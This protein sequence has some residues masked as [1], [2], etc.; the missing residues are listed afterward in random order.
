MEGFEGFE[1]ELKDLTPE[2]RE[3]AIELAHQYLQRP[4]YDRARA[5]KEAIADAEA[6]YMESEG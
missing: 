3:K 2:V 6:W 1:I 5:I 4:G